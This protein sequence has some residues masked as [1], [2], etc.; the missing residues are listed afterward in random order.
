MTS[1]LKSI[2]RVKYCRDQHPC[3]LSSLP[4]SSYLNVNIRLLSSLNTQIDTLTCN[5]KPISVILCWCIS[6]VEIISDYVNQ[7][8]CSAV[9][10]KASN[11]W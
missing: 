7:P 9:K 10:I 4:V 2:V 11:E 5:F 8:W 3:N 1:L 6:V